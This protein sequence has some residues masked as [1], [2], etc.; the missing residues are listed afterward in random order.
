MSSQGPDGCYWEE[1]EHLR[2]LAQSEYSGHCGHAFERDS[3][4]LITLLFIS[5]HDVSNFNLLHD[6]HHHVLPCHM[7]KAKEQI[8]HAPSPPKL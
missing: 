5:S 4:S 2:G 8:I 7:L 6:S 3:R 1:V